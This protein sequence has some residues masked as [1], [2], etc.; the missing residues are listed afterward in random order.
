MTFNPIEHACDVLHLT[1]PNEK[2]AAALS[3]REHWHS[4]CRDKYETDHAPE[5]KPGRP[6]K[7]DLVLPSEVPRRRLGSPE[8]RGALLHAIAHIELN[9]ID[10][11][12][13][14]IARF[15]SHPLIYPDLQSDFIEDWSQVCAEE[16]KHFNLLTNRMASLGVAYGDYPAHNGL[17]DA[18]FKTRH[19]IAARLAIAP[20]VLEARGLDVTP[21]MIAKLEKVGDEK[22]VAILK[23]IYKDE[24]GHVKIGAKW[25]QNIAQL[26]GESP[27]PYFHKLV[28]THFAGRLK[29][30]FNVQARTLAGL[31]EDYYAPLAI[32]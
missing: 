4:S 28:K 30:P 8:G 31:T 17:W 24:I 1:S 7:P 16:A 23:V 20:M 2:A 12:A 6:K 3:L 26:E 14:M 10:L 21:G 25:F 19:D 22:S 29:P 13:D 18:A 15:A 9:A 32:C 5:S 27:R 11:A